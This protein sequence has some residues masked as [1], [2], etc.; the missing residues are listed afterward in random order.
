[1][2]HKEQAKRLAAEIDNLRQQAEKASMFQLKPLV[3]K[4]GRL[5]AEFNLLVVE[6]L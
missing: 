2:S 3:E 6:A 5:Q 4:M 1:M